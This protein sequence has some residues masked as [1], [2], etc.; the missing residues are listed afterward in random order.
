MNAPKK[1]PPTLPPAAKDNPNVKL[2][3]EVRDA[4]GVIIN[5]LD[6]NGAPAMNALITMEFGDKVLIHTE[7]RDRTIHT[8]SGEVH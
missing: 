7:I 6:R 4:F 1:A 8:Y 5:Y 3:T 2:P